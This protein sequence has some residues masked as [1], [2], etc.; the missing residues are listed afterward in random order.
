MRDGKMQDHKPVLAQTEAVGH[1]VRA[2]YMYAAMTD[3]ARFSEAPEYA[4]VVRTLSLEEQAKIKDWAI[5][6]VGGSRKYLAR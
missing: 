6:Y 4:K 5:K 3:L 1:A 2:G